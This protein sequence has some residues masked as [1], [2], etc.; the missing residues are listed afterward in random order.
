MQSNFIQHSSE[1]NESINLLCGMPKG[2][3]NNNMI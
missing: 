2:S 3:R 1:K